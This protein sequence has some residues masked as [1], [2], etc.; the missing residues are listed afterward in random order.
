MIDYFGSFTYTNGLPYPDTLAVNA[1]G[2]SATDGTEFV[3]LMIDDLWGARQALMDYAGLTPDGVTEAPGSAQT[4]EAIGKGFGVGPGMGVIYW[5]DGDPAVNGDRVLLLN[6]QG[7][8]R[9]NYAE[10]DAAVY[11]GDGNNGTA[12]AFYHAD[13]AAGTVRNIAGAYLIL[14]DTRG[15]FLRGLDVAASVDPDGASRDLGSIQIDSS[16][17]H[18]HYIGIAD[19]SNVI[20]VYGATTLELPGSATSQVTESPDTINYQGLTSTPRPD[21][22]NGTPRNSTETRA[23]NIATKFGITY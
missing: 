20:Y 14:P 22:V 15:Y 7:I 18:L 11:V 8:L 13:D 23:I 12:S 5:K 4:L 6:G 21:G 10:L 19:N 16:Q 3:K 1:S 9:A 2:P 17:G